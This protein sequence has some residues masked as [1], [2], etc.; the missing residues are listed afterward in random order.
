MSAARRLDSGA[1]KRRL[2]VKKVRFAT[3]EE[4]A[5][6]TGLVPGSVPPFGRPV[7]DLD[8]FVDVSVSDQQK[9]SFNAGS[10]T[11]SIAMSAADY[12]AVADADV[13]CFSK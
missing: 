13:F 2:K 4:L 12:M 3:P 9:V 1:V 5:A 6:L 11:D 10:L 8:L 7:F